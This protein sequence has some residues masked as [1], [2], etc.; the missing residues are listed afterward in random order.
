MC[1]STGAVKHAYV[2]MLWSFQ[3]APAWRSYGSEHPRHPVPIPSSFKCQQSL[4]LEDCCL[5]PGCT[6]CK[7]LYLQCDCIPS[8]TRPAGATQ[9][10]EALAPPSWVFLPRVPM[11][12]KKKK[13]L[14]GYKI[15]PPPA[16]FYSV[17]S[18]LAPQ[19]STLVYVKNMALRCSF[20]LKFCLRVVKNENALFF[21][22][23][24]SFFFQMT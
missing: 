8:Q 10:E 9:A 3:A 4:L 21:Y 1:L 23:F 19:Y 7:V 15:A 22:K 12:L 14:N 24:Y 20:R 16:I 2:G 13:I 5:A 17:F 6:Q 11:V 18:S